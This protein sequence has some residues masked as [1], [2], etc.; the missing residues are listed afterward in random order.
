MTRSLRSLLVETF[1]FRSIR[2]RLLLLVGALL[3]LGAL[4]VAVMSWGS[5]QRTRALSDLLNAIDRQRLILEVRNRL[6]DQKKFVDLIG[7]GVVDLGPG[8]APPDQEIRRFDRAADSIPLLLEVLE[9]TDDGATEDSIRALRDQAEELAAL[10]KSF[11]VNQGVDASAAVVASVQAEPIAQ[12][13]LSQGLPAA[14]AREEVRVTRARAAFVETDRTVSRATLLG[15]VVS[16]LVGGVL[17][18]VILRRVFSSIRGLKRGADRIGAGELDHRIEARGGDELANVAESF[19]QMAERLHDRTQEIE[20]QRRISEDLLLNILPRHIAAELRERG[21]VEAKYCPDTTILF[22]DLVG[23]TRLFDSLS[24]DRMVRLLDRLVTEFDRIIRVYGLEKL[25]TIGDAY[26]CVGGLGRSGA[27]HPVDAVLAACEIVETVRRLADAEG[28]DLDIR[29]GIHTGPVAAGVVGIDKFAFDVWGDAV[30][31]AARLETAS[32]PGRINLSQNTWLRIKDFFEC[33]QRGKVGTKE[34]RSYDMW[35]FEGIHPELAGPGRPP[36]AFAHRY[37]I[38]FECE[39]PAFP[40]SLRM[41][42]GSAK[43]TTRQ[44]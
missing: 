11:Y 2:G 1:D 12:E 15:F 7:T 3:A 40:E 42:E 10:W 36:E 5:S 35:F 28:L 18:W 24:V 26:M 30:N 23:F 14:V 32:A 8:A 16:A 13:L 33:V 25:K 31:F 22:T 19:N 37:R 44:A 34:G 21:K 6:E 27:S 41:P 29:A 39:P 9:T 17:A 4:N 38:Y 43:P 20:R